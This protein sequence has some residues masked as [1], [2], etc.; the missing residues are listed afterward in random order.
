MKAK[1][2]IVNSFNE[3]DPLEEVIVGRIDG[4]C[5]PYFDYAVKTNTHPENWWFF[6]KFGG[7]PF[8]KELIEPA[9][10]ELDEFSRVLENEGVIV[11]RPDY[12]DFSTK[13]KTPDFEAVGLYAAMPRD[14]LIT[15]GN[16][17][18]EAPMAW[19][20]RFFEYR[21]YR[22][23]LK[24]YLLG[25]AKW[26]AAPKPLMA[27]ALYDE[28]YPLQ[29][30]AELAAQG[31]FVTTEFEPCFDAADIVRFGKDIFLQ[32]SHVTN[33]MGI[34]WLKNHLAD[35]F[36][37]HVIQFK[38]PN[39]MH[40]DASLIPLRPGLALVNPD[41]PCYQI[42]LFKKAGW[43]I[44]PGVPSTLPRDWPLYMSR[45][46]L[47]LNILS[48][49]PNCVIVERQEEPLKKLLKDL[50]FRIIPVDFRHVYTFGGS[51]HCVTCDTRR[52]GKLENYGFSNP[53]ESELVWKS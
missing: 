32:R 47:C 50:G 37:V 12:V 48:L 43:D 13:Y 53:V 51:F 16:E 8:P 19:R 52:K 5:V 49:D 34:T 40:I 29:S 33:Q 25:G 42:D 41:R 38:D 14:I 22:S 15:V 44:V 35:T 28:N 23:L 30:I 18:I 6:E 10:K 4:A 7:K 21:A 9:Q 2:Q 36:R 11:R 27:D 39:P 17:I 31:K 46:W 1:K 45:K 3:W 24:E 26:T 20:A